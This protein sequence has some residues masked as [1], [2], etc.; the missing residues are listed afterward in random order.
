MHRFRVSAQ[1]PFPVATPPRRRPAHDAPPSRAQLEDNLLEDL[2]LLEPGIVQQGP[3]YP[4]EPLV[5]IVSRERASALPKLREL[6]RGEPEI[7]I[8]V[9]RRVADRRGEDGDAAATHERRVAER[10][11]RFSFYLL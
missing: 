1:V 3:E 2:R 6:L 11:R 7:S 5:L 4:E 10:R 9:D 8:V